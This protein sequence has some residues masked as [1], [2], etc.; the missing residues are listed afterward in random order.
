MTAVS[1]MSARA[2]AE[3]R[4]VATEVRKSSGQALGLKLDAEAGDYVARIIETLCNQV[5]APQPGVEASVEA[6]K[7]PNASL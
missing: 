7:P 5:E 6:E 1:P 2:I 3:A 4:R